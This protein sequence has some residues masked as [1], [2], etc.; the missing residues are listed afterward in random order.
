MSSS[1]VLA[2]AL[3]SVLV[4]GACSNTESSVNRRPHTGTAT[5]S[6]V[7]GVQQVRI[8]AGDDYR[9][10]P[11]TIVVH[12]GT[13]EIVLVHTGTG[14]PHDWSLTGFPADFVPLTNAGDTRVARF[15]APSPGKYQFVCTIHARQG[16]T[17]TLVVRS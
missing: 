7:A 5:A 11:S 15:V 6:T 13:V 9:F 17:G 3:A 12:P 8:E 16:Q 4:L 1:R 10:H 2:G 14:G